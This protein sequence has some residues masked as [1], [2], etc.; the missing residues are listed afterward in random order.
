M[1][2]IT[3]VCNAMRCLCE[4]VVG[5]IVIADVNSCACAEKN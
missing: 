1:T 3:C 5:V 4:V 2:C